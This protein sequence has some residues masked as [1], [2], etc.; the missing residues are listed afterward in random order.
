MEFLR[1][2]AAD[3]VKIV[4]AYMAPWTNAFGAGL[5]GS[6]YN[7]AKTHKFGGF[8]ITTSVNV[9]FVPSSART[10]NVEN[11]GLTTLSGS[12]IAPTVAGPD[13]AGP[14]LTKTVDG[15]QLASFTLP[16]GTGWKMIPVPT[17]QVGIG[18]PL[19]TELKFRYIPR[20]SIKGSNVSLWGVGLMHSIMQY[21]PG[22]KLSPFDVSI[23][24]GYTRLQANVPVSLLP[25]PAV[26]ANFGTFINPGSFETQKMSATLQGW[27]VSAIA[28]FTIPIVTFYG[29]LG[30][31][32]TQTQI[33]LKGNYP[34]PVL[35]A[36]PTPHAEYNDSGVLSGSQIPSV[37]I[38]NFS[39]LRANIGVRFKLSVVTINLDYT[40]SQYNVVSAGLGISFR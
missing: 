3:G 11:L 37:D 16:P 4:Q 38:K 26:N 28:S 2:G 30:Y 39:G 8:D 19:G 7:T 9:G 6:W 1:A 22:N 21:I 15:I 32:K 18:L 13:Q 40:S 23:F 24:G 35:A 34:T 20:I 36:T 17:A 10:Y 5:N 33:V 27:N 25:D 29:G 31:S 12:G 14:Y